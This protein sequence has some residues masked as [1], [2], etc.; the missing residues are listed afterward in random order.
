MSVTY[1]WDIETIDLETGDLHGDY[2]EIVNHNFYDKC[3][4]IPTEPNRRLALVRDDKLGRSW[5]YVDKDGILSDYLLDA[6][7]DIVVNTPYRFVE[8]LNKTKEQ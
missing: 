5:A 3:P 7:N 4:G 8:E 1:E 6:Y 2:T